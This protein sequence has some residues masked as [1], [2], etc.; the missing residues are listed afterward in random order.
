MEWGLIRVIFKQIFDPFFTTKGP[1]SS[2]LGLSI[3]YNL[4]SQS[5]GFLTVASP[6]GLGTTFTA[7][8]P[9]AP[10]Q[11]ANLPGAEDSTAE[12]GSL[13]ILVADDELLVAGMLKTFLE[14][15]GHNVAVCLNGAEAI[16]A[17]ENKEFDLAVVDLAMPEVD[18]W[19]V[20]R[21]VNELRPEVPIIVVTGWNM[22]VG[23]W[24][25]ARRNRRFCAQKALCHGRPNRGCGPRH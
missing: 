6:P 3:A 19:Q 4:V 17:F 18:G 7:R 8:F 2:G 20:S 21:R 15:V 1:G 16:E 13:R 23:G 14:S 22:T 25:G 9:A 10:S 11:L 12:V 24:P 5:G